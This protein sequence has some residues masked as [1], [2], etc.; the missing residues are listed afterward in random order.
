MKIFIK[1]DS[2]LSVGT[3]VFLSFGKCFNVGLMSKNGVIPF[4]YFQVSDMI[5]L[6]TLKTCS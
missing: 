6:E 3:I 1:D 4:T 2:S 5:M